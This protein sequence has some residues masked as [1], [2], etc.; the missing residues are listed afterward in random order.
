MTGNMK[1]AVVV[2]VIIALLAVAIIVM[3]NAKPNQAPSPPVSTGQAPGAAANQPAPQTSSGQAPSQPPRQVAVPIEAKVA[4]IAGDTLTLTQSK[5]DQIQPFLDPKNFL[6]APSTSSGQATPQA[7]KNTFS[8]TFT[9]KTTAATQILKVTM[10][11]FSQ[12]Q[13]EVQQFLA[14][15]AAPQL[16]PPQPFASQ[17]TI[18]IKDIKS[19]DHLVAIMAGEQAQL[20]TVIE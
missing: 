18:T 8:Q 15:Q 20:I 1:S 6:P 19:G 16:P 3:V 14:K 9:A 10:K 7:P 17:K 12:Y 2:T 11:P 4:A 5:T 13:K